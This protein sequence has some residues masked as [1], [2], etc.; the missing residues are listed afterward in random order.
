MSGK[1]T[2]ERRLPAVDKTKVDPQLR[3]AAE[4]MEAMFL[5]FL[6]QTMRN[7]VPQSDMS[8]DTPASRMYTSMLDN[9]MSQ[10]AA[11][12]GGVGLAEQIIAYMESQRYNEMQGQDASTKPINDRDGGHTKE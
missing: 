7:T 8:L 6:M 9:E 5:D 11:R 3:N 4:G 1:I 10:K 2:P 12:A